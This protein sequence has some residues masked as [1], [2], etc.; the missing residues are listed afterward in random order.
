MI[1]SYKWIAPFVDI[2]IVTAK[3]MVNENIGKRFLENEPCGVDEKRIAGGQSSLRFT[4]V[5]HGPM[6]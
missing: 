5:F 3:K 6:W 2:I 4:L 1:F